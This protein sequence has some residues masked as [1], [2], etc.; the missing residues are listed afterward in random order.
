MDQFRSVPVGWCLSRHKRQQEVVAVALPVIALVGRLL[1]RVQRGPQ[2]VH[3]Y[4]RGVERYSGGVQAGLRGV[5]LRLRSRPALRRRATARAR[6]APLTLHGSS[7]SSARWSHQPCPTLR[8]QRR[9]GDDE[10]AADLPPRDSFVPGARLCKRTTRP[11]STTSLTIV[12]ELCDCGGRSRGNIWRGPE[13]CLG[14]Y[15]R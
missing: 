8:V 14:Q 9:K 2:I 11:R 15:S 3:R 13:L 6:A 12:R 4:L 7:L 1:E 5:M 10:A